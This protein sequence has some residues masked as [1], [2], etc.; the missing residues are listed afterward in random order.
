MAAGVRS[1]RSKSSIRAAADQLRR[2]PAP[3]TDVLHIR[4][5]RLGRAVRGPHPARSRLHGTDQLRRR[6]LPRPAFVWPEQDGMAGPVWRLRSM[7]RRT[8]SRAVIALPFVEVNA[9]FLVSA[10]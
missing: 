10:T 2:R 9:V 4:L 6:T 7:T 8:I 5:D 1:G 3:A